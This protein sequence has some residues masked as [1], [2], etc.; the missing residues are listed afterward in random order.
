MP[1]R[2]SR[3]YII[4]ESLLG[5]ASCPGM[6]QRHK[7]RQQSSDLKHHRNAAQFPPVRKNMPGTHNQNDPWYLL[8][9]ESKRQVRNNQLAFVH[10][11]RGWRR[12][13]LCFSIK[14]TVERLKAILLQSNSI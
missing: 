8:L 10:D 11:V 14:P 13:T 3:H 5:V 6:G 12:T 2:C 9:N 1:L 7:N 4:K